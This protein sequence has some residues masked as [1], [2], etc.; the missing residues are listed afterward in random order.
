MRDDFLMDR[1]IDE[2]DNDLLANELMEAAKAIARSVDDLF[3]LHPVAMMVR[4]A[5]HLNL[6]GDGIKE[7]DAQMDYRDYEA[8]LDNLDTDKTLLPLG[9]KSLAIQ[10]FAMTGIVMDVADDEPAQAHHVIQEL[11]AWG[12]RVGTALP[13]SASAPFFNH[14]LCG[15]KAR[16]ALDQGE[17]VSVEDLATLASIARWP[18]ER[19]IGAEIFEIPKKT[20]Q[21]LVSAGTL[22]RTESGLISAASAS[23]WIS[24]QMQRED[25]FPS[26]AFLPP[27]PLR[28]ESIADPVFV[29]ATRSGHSDVRALFT[30]GEKHE[31]G[32]HIR[33]GEKSEVLADYW[34]ALSMLQESE[35]PWFKPKL[36]TRDLPVDGWERRPRAALQQ[37]ASA[38]E[39]TAPRAQEQSTLSLTAQI[40]RRLKGDPR[41]DVHRKGHTSKVLRYSTKAGIE[42][43]IEKRRNAPLIYL[44]DTMQMR[45]AVKPWLVDTR[46]ASLSGRNSNL[47]ALSSFRDKPLLVMRPETVEEFAKILEAALAAGEAS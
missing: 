4:A 35:N 47:N 39:S 1:F 45:N 16:Y 33:V 9:G 34:E 10:C 36:A 25:L 31:D 22:E 28:N 21:N 38:I 14:F 19:P 41:V 27:E 7:R 18:L 8:A 13:S 46:A 26:M 43:A 15:A 20:V 24:D 40:E 6:M 44:A 32:Y 23:R 5:D 37:E 30:P 2:H 17:S 3:G 42:L 12:D 29:P 11:L